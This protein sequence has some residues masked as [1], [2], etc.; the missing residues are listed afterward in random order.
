MSC[1]DPHP[2]HK[3]NNSLKSHMS[4]TDATPRPGNAA[5]T[6]GGESTPVLDLQ[7]LALLIAAAHQAVYVEQTTVN[8]IGILLEDAVHFRFDCSS[9]VS[10]VLGISP[11]CSCEIDSL[12]H[13]SVLYCSIIVQASGDWLAESADFCRT[14]HLTTSLLP[15]ARL[16]GCAAAAA[17][18]LPVKAE[19]DHPACLSVPCLLHEVVLHATLSLNCATRTLFDLLSIWQR[20]DGH[21]M[22]ASPLHTAGSDMRLLGALQIVVKGP[23]EASGVGDLP[24]RL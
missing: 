1:S 23:K 16:R 13:A 15:R 3:Y 22:V 4:Y 6:A 21:T 7:S 11:S 8:A 5:T 9:R 18:R 24:I 12:Q 14:G 19:G 2:S 17:A 10:D 20:A